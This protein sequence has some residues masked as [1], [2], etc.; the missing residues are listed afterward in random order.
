L[1][2]FLGGGTL[3]I[4]IVEVFRKVALFEYPRPPDFNA[5]EL[6]AKD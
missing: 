6:I 3:M 2:E 1:C 4:Q 5:L